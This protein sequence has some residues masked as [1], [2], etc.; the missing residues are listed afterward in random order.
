MNERTDGWTD[1]RT[2][3]R[4]VRAEILVSAVDSPQRFNSFDVHEFAASA[5]L[6]QLASVRRGK[7]TLRALYFPATFQRSLNE[8]R[9]RDIFPISPPPRYSYTQKTPWSL[10]RS[11][12]DRV[13]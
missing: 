5:T 1:E 9:G 11:R 3:G 7:T 2:D 13:Q 12:L 8:R 6:S 4:A 10:I